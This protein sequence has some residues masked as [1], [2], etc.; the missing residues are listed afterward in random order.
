MA[1]LDQSVLSNARDLAVATCTID[2]MRIK[3]VSF[4][5]EALASE[6]WS[7]LREL[8]KL[9]SAVD[10][11]DVNFTL[12][13]VYGPIHA[14]FSHAMRDGKAV[15][16]YSFD[17]LARDINGR[18]SAKHLRTILF[19]QHG[20]ATWTSNGGWDWQPE[21]RGNNLA[22]NRYQFFFGLLADAQATLQDY[23][24]RA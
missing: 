12:S 21:G 13:T 16:A 9:S 18:Y 11:I 19:D 2:E 17:L 10:G 5:D 1:G 22:E 20:R 3:F 15:G 24:E 14:T 8:G 7:T 6:G 23:P 4:V